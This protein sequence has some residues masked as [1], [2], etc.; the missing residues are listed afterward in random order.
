MKE[1]LDIVDENNKVIGKADWDETR[2]NNL[3]HRGSAIL[4]FNSKKELF[5]HKRSKQMRKYPNLFS[6]VVGGGVSSGESYDDNAIRELEEEVGI[7]DVK[8]NFL[9]QTLFN[10]DGARSFINVYSCVYDGDMKFQEEEVE[11]GFFIS[12]KKLKEM[13]KKE[14]FSP[15]SIHVFNEYIE[16]HHKNDPTVKNL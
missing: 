1:Y 8:L 13:I 11:H 12:L 14:R 9:F 16:K 15:P 10:G 4:I 7:K 5:I 2:Q 3:L 6:T